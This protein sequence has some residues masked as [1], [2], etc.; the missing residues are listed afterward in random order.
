MFLKVLQ[1]LLTEVTAFG[2]VETWL[3]FQISISN[4]KLKKAI[5]HHTG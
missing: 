5:D 1:T 2:D 3:Q 4:L